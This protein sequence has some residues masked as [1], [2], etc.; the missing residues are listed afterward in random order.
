MS[1]VLSRSGCGAR[2][3]S[4]RL[5][6]CAGPGLGAPVPSTRIPR[7]A[8]LVLPLFAA[9]LAVALAS[10]GAPASQRSLLL[11]VI[12]TLRYDH[13]GAYGYER[14]TTPAL[15]R[16][17]RDSVLVERAYAA[18][19]WT[20]PSVASIL[21]GRFPRTHGA[22]TITSMIRDDVE[23]LAQRLSASGFATAGAVSNLHLEPGNGFGR[24]FE[25]YL[26]SEARDQLY[27]STESV[28]DQA[29]ELLDGLAGDAPFFLFVHY[30]DPHY[31]YIDHVQ[32]EYEPTQVE[33]LDG[34]E[35]LDELRARMPELSA[36]QVAFIVLGS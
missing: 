32:F 12:D 36:E 16:L 33:G 19:P 10:C 28:T 2:A 24:G 14:E 20:R 11:V 18:A 26:Y 21:T 25:R 7:R 9:Y 34:D 35:T 31:R 4:A 6:R 22:N 3:T 23:T 8:S 15:D 29:I 13:L 5:G 1:G 30:F 27:V 17:A